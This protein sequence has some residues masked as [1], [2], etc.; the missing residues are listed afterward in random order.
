MLLED[1][2]VNHV[3][4]AVIVL[5]ESKEKGMMNVHVDLVKIALLAKKVTN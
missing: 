1:K 5:L 4:H 3:L 2:M